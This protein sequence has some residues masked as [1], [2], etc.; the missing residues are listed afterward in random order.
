MEEIEEKQERKRHS[1]WRRE[2]GLPPETIS[3]MGANTE[4]GRKVDAAIKK[5][6]QKKVAAEANKKVP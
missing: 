6:L 5:V 2:N 3:N 1:Q 4:V